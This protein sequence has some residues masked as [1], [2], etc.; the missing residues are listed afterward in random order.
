M[1]GSKVDHEHME[2]NFLVRIDWGT[3]FVGFFDY[4]CE[5]SRWLWNLVVSVGRVEVV[6]YNPLCFANR[7]I[8]QPTYGYNIA[9]V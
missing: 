3:D 6:V 5:D 9:P 2:R 8:Q 1:T 7:W 4:P